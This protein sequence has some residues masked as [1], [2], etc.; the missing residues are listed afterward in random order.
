M[1]CAK[2]LADTVKMLLER[3]VDLNLSPLVPTGNASRDLIPTQSVMLPFFY[4]EA[5]STKVSGLRPVSSV[6]LDSCAVWLGAAAGLLPEGG[7]GGHGLLSNVGAF[8]LSSE[9]WCKTA[10][11]WGP[12]H[13]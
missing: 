2:G 9:Q 7:H 11:D 6:H 4:H 8:C 3:H 13:D 12:T 1:L 10:G 5:I